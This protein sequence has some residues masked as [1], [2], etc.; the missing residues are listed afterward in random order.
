MGAEITCPG[1]RLRGQLTRH[2]VVL[3][4]DAEGIGNAVEEGK[5]C[6]YVNSL[7]DLVFRPACLS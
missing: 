4:R 1:A 3:G 7:G 6:D 2:K 5:H